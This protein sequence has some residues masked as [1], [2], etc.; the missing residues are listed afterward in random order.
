M[1]LHFQ[2]CTTSDSYYPYA[3]S[4]FMKTLAS[5]AWLFLHNQEHFELPEEFLISDADGC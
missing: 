3:L 5:Q 2:S 4:L 1:G